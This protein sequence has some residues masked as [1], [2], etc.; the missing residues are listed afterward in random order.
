ML[1]QQR[2]WW[3]K[4]SWRPC[5]PLQPA[6]MSQLNAVHSLA[7]PHLRVLLQQY[8]STPLH[9]QADYGF[10][11]VDSFQRFS[12]RTA[13]LPP[14][15]NNNKWCPFKAAGSSEDAQH[16]PLIRC[17]SFFLFF[18][19]PFQ[20]SLLCNWSYLWH[21]LCRFSPRCESHRCVCCFKGN[22]IRADGLIHVAEASRVGCR[23][24]CINITGASFKSRAYNTGR[25]DTA[26]H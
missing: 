2:L 21:K 1:F 26:R 9:G 17:I 25:I 18:F 3:I 15:S 11:Q 13:Y 19:F 8:P 5:L 7:T 22:V 24:S 14:Y 4:T 6:N 20:I 12:C 16:F 10:T 23:E